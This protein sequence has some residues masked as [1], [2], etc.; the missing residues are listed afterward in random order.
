MTTCAAAATYISTIYLVSRLH[1]NKSIVDKMRMIAPTRPYYLEVSIM[2]FFA[3]LFRTNY[4][5]GFIEY[6]LSFPQLGIILLLL[7]KG[8]FIKG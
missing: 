1:N 6:V 4:L 2:T 3:L 7:R 5:K 8:P